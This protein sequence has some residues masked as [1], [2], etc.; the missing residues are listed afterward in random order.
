V[1]GHAIDQQRPNAVAA[2]VAQRHGRD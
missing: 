2:H 1:T